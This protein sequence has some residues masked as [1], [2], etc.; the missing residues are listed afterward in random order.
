M[1]KFFLALLLLVVVIGLVGPKFAGNSFNNQLDYFAE[2]L[3]EQPFY[4]ASIE[5][6]EQGWFSTSASL[7][8]SLDMGELAGSMNSADQDALSF[9]VPIK[10]Q[11]GPVLTQS[12]LGLGWV[13]WQVNLTLSE[14]S[15]NLELPE[16]NAFIYS[17]EG[18]YG[19]LGTTSYSDLVPALTYTDPESGLTFSTTGWQGNARLTTDTFDYESDQASSF[20]VSVF[21]TK[22]ASVENMTVKSDIEAGLMQTWE[23]SLYNGVATI[24]IGTMSFVNPSTSEET[25]LDN[26]VM[27]LD[28][29]YDT[30]TELGDI[31]IST[32]IAS[33]VNSTFTMQDLQLD[34]AINNLQRSFFKAYQKMSEDIIDSPEQA[35]V[36]MQAFLQD[37]VLEQLQANPELNLPQIKGVI[38]ESKFDGYAN[39]KLVDVQALPDTLDDPAF[40]AEH[41]V[42]DAKLLV[43]EGAALF[44][45]EMTLRSQLRANPQFS[46]MSEEDK[47]AIV[48]QQSQATIEALVQQGLLTKIDE[49]YEFTFTMENAQAML[50]GNPMPLPF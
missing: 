1:K 14:P 43:E 41:A 40:W 29:D 39:S 9:T 7:V 8:I 26:V 23:Q 5:D 47:N 18:I 35:D 33:F 50:N 42:V 48:A 28:S 13:D 49:G 38:N 25:R 30:S 46:Q 34:Y 10:A 32:K 15:E 16:G 20:E 22:V 45:A 3:S 6:R 19:L 12:G 4:K 27:D 17:A 24:S 37:S 44:I 2:K 21:G 11:H 36:I 31:L